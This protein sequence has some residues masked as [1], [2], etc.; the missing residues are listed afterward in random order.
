MQEALWF[1]SFGLNKIALLYGD[2]PADDSWEYSL[3]D[4]AWKINQI[5]PMMQVSTEDACQ[6][7]KEKVPPAPLFGYA[8]GLEIYLH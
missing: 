6:M 5:C 3:D 2:F 4:L 8:C 7:R 1:H